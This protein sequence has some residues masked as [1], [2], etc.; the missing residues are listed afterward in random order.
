[1][2]G[3]YDYVAPSYWLV[4]TGKF[5]GAY[6]FN[7]ET[8]PGPAIPTLSSLHRFLPKDHLWP[9]DDIWSLHNGGGKFKTLDVFDTAMEATYGKPSGVEDYVRVAQ[10]MAFSGERAMFEAYGRNKYTSTGVIQW[11][12]NNAWPSMI[13]HLYDYYLDAGGGYFGAKKAC[14]PLHIQYSYDDHSVTIVNSRYEEAA[15]LTAS[16]QVYDLHLKPLFTNQAEVNAGA[17][18][19]VK[20]F[21][22]PDSV[23]NADTQIIFVKLILK[24]H[25]GQ[26]TS[27][28]FYW[29]P[30]HLTEFDWE[31]T[32]YTHTPAVRHEDLTALHQLPESHV[33]ATA[34][35]VSAK[36]VRVRLHNPSKALAFQVSVAATD[37]K[38]QDITPTLWSDNYIELLPGETRVLT[39]Q[40]PERHPAHIV[41]SGWNIK[42][43]ML[44]PAA[45]KTA[46]AAQ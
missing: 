19:S 35:T 9:P 31:K 23:F 20:A 26:I 1:M 34:Q 14:E 7:T 5:G 38:G 2:S 10:T 6:G 18:A 36:D 41:V 21:S 17:D 30:T 32:D 33:E 45:E 27:E 22:I 28:N 39:A 16:A 42:S 13:W 46:T 44:T 12:L 43:Q 40:L 3:P 29:V 11:M 8:G 25:Q 4:D 24:D 15:H 37:E